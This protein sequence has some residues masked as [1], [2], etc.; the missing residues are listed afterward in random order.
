MHFINFSLYIIVMTFLGDSLH[1]QFPLD[2]NNQVK[3]MFIFGALYTMFM[4]MPI[5]I[6]YL[7]SQ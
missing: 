6:L 1:R 7:F 3:A 5:M 2:K 4:M